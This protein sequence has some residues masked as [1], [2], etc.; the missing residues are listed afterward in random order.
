[1]KTM[2]FYAKTNR[3]NNRLRIEADGCMVEIRVGLTTQDGERVTRVDIV[4]DKFRDGD[5]RW[6]L[7]DE[8]GNSVGSQSDRGQTI[9]VVTRDAEDGSLCPCSPSPAKARK[10][11]RS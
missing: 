6:G 2:T 8:A 4:P 11:T 5:K 10:R 3:S 1:M 9:N 7:L